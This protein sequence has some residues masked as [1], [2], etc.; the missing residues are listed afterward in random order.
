[1]NAAVPEPST[2]LRRRSADHHDSARLDGAIFVM[3]RCR[4]SL[5]CARGGVG[6]SA[7][8]RR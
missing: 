1:M 8:R 5:V 4:R 2:R 6:A 3:R 7:E